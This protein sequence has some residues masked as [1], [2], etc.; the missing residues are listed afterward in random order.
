M[1]LAALNL[2]GCLE[3]TSTDHCYLYNGGTILPY[4]T[5]EVTTPCPTWATAGWG[6]NHQLVVNCWTEFSQTQSRWT[7][8]ISIYISRIGCRLDKLPLFGLTN[9][10]RPTTRKT[11]KLH[12]QTGYGIK[13]ETVTV[14]HLFVFANKFS[15]EAQNPWGILHP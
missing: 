13:H 3:Y 12:L 5:R 4:L 6:R 2:Y 7:Y 9:F 15:L 10:V 14:F 8:N 1:H 11:K